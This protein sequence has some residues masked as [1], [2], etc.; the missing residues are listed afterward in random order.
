MINLDATRALI[1]RAAADTGDGL[2]ARE[3]LVALAGEMADEIA[4]DRGARLQ[5]RSVE[6]RVDRER[7]CPAKVRAY[8]SANGWTLRDQHP[9]ASV[10]ANPHVTRHGWAKTGSLVTVLD[11]TWFSDY[12]RHLALTVVDLADLHGLGE[13]G[14]LAGIEAAEVPGDAG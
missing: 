3:L 10:W 12:E 9:K 11:T 7:H 4:A 14:V 2:D 1:A 6:K 8:L 5:P 13:L